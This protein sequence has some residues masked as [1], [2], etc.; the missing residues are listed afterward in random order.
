MRGGWSQARVAV[1]GSE[2]TVAVELEGQ[3]Q[4]L[5]AVVDIWGERGEFSGVR[6]QWY[7]ATR[8]AYRFGGPRFLG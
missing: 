8:L 2:G 6:H 5:E 3:L 1:E 7:N 4:P